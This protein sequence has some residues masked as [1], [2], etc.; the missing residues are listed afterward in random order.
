MDEPR[1]PMELIKQSDAMA[2]FLDA[3]RQV[4]DMGAVRFA[5]MGFEVVFERAD[6]PRVER[7][8]ARKRT[9]DER[10]KEERDLLVRAEQLLRG[11]GNGG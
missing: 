2:L 6:A 11:A 1:K 7:E 3:A 9:Y 8:P 5:A 10:P 4:R